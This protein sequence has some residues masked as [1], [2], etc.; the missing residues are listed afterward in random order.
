MNGRTHAAIGAGLMLMSAAISYPVG[1]S[2]AREAA[3]S[4]SLAAPAV[5]Q[6]S[7]DELVGPFDILDVSVLQLESV[8]RTVE[9]SA[10]G[11]ISLPLA[12]DFNVAGKTT[13][14]IAADIADRLG[15]HDLQNP[16]V[17]VTLKDANQQTVSLKDAARRGFTVEGS[18]TQPGVYYI[19]GP[20]TLMQ[21][22]AMTKGADQYAD[23][24]HVTI[25]RETDGRSNE[26][27]Y[28]L[29]DVRRGKVE[30]PQIYARDII[31]VAGSRTK[32]FVRDFGPAFPLIYLMP[33]I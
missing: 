11:M 8:S 14:Q 27:I 19:Y 4:D 22:L 5:S 2:A 3:G 21:G 12:G 32:H 10:T 31:V 33:K 17:T 28:N 16:Q 29:A 13:N 20:I 25:I 23:D 18:V 26:K 24:K 9:V 30:D 15:R 6:P 1:V 7:Q